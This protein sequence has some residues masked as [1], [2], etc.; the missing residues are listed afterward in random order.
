MSKCFLVLDKGL[1][2]DSYVESFSPRWGTFPNPCHLRIEAEL[3]SEVL[4]LQLC[5]TISGQN[6]YKEYWWK[7]L[8]NIKA[9]QNW[10]LTTCFLYDRS[11]YCKYMSFPLLQRFDYSVLTPFLP[12]KHEYVIS[13]RLCEVQIKAYRYY[14]ENCAMGKSGVNSK[15]AQLFSDYQHLS[16]IWTHP[17]VLQMSTETAE[18]NAEKK[19]RQLNHRELHAFFEGRL[20][21][22][23]VCFQVLYLSLFGARHIVCMKCIVMLTIP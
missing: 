22:S 1:K 11:Q 12:P 7:L 16:R 13:I 17:R 5:V 10:N 3:V 4:W 2:P 9:L 20:L 21:G 14:L 8:S 15:G 6:A 19:V 18:K 23:M